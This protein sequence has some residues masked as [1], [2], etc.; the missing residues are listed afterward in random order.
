[1]PPDPV[2]LGSPADWL[3]YA[4]SDLAVSEGPAAPNVLTETLCYHAQQA[5]EKCLKAVLVNCGTDPPRT[6]DIALL[7]TA[8][9]DAGIDWPSE[10]DCAA[11]LTQYAVRSRYP[12]WP[13]P[14]SEAD[15]QQ[16]VAVARKVLEWAQGIISPS[17][18]NT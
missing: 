11:D 18:R 16:A 2:P 1:M 9:R 6:H 13:R 10:L 12:G 5:A 4:L 14:P 7:V 15:R 8:V 3:R 17:G